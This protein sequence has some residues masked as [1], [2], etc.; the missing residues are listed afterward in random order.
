MGG[1]LSV[2][3]LYPHHAIQRTPYECEARDLHRA[4]GRSKGLVCHLHLQEPQVRE[5]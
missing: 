5:P 4:R 1:R 3:W 2:L